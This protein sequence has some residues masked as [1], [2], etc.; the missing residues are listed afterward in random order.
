M[1]IF[2]T[3]GRYTAAA[4]KGMVE[5][6]EDR[7]KAVADLFEHIGGKLLAFY[8]TFGEY[9][10]LSIVE[11]PDAETELAA[12]LAGMSKGAVSDMRTM[13]AVTPDSFRQAC[14]TAGKLAPSFKAAG[15]DE[16]A[17]RT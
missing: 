16:V 14:E 10:W 2:I 1:P 17:A 11:V 6:A 15:F 9:D 7:A 5:H 13:L 4:V 8:V 12:L 3:Q